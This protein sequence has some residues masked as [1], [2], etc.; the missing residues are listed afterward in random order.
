MSWLKTRGYLLPITNYYG[1]K[2]D[3]AYTVGMQTLKS[4]IN[5]RKIDQEGVVGDP[6]LLSWK[7]L[8]KDT[9][10]ASR[11]LRILR[12]STGK[13][14]PFKISI[15]FLKFRALELSI[16]FM[17]QQLL[18]PAINYC[19]VKGLLCLWYKLAFCR[20]IMNC[21]LFINSPHI[22]YLHSVIS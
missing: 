3:W 10:N 14:N 4:H 6:F 5:H 7:L 17:H 13:V 19:N 15:L 18:S 16:L 2:Y 11:I 22:H 1:A 8:M 9:I 21:N 20:L 12:V